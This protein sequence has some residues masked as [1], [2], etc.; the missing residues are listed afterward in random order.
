LACRFRAL[1]QSLQF[2]HHAAVQPGV[3]A[4]QIFM[5]GRIVR[6]LLGHEDVGEGRVH[7]IVHPC[8]RL[9]GAGAR[10][11][12]SRQEAQPGKTVVQVSDDGQDLRDHLCAV[13]QHRNLSARV[14]RP[15]LRALLFA[16]VQ[17]DHHRFEGGAAGF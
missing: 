12:F 4:P 8:Q 2:A 6:K 10:Q 15:V 13:H 7:G 11:R 14:D 1:H 17:F 9:H 3:V 16:L 5:H